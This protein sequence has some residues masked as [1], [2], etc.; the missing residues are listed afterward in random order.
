MGLRKNS[1]FWEK[2]TIYYAR[3]KLNKRKILFR[4]DKLAAK[5]NIATV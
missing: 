4:E 3:T 2:L 1:K 5:L